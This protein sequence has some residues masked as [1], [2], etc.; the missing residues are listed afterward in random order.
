GLLG[1]FLLLASFAAVG[2]FMSTLTAQPAVAAVA[3]FGA[4]LL[5][6]IVDWGAGA[7]GEDNILA[8]LSMLRHYEPLLRGAFSS[9]DVAYYL[10]VIVTFLAF[11]I[12]RLDS[13]RLQH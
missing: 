4:L 2:L 7:G 10:L 9:A 13:Y 8:H 5:L 3:G 1:L 11:S 6:W 12:R